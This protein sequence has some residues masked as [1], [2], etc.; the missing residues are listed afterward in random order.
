MSKGSQLNMLSQISNVNV[1][2]FSLALK[3][4][5]YLVFH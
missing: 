4:S 1:F 5:E 2:T 3:L